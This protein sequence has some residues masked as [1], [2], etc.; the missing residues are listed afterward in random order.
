MIEIKTMEM[1]EKIGSEFAGQATYMEPSNGNQNCR[2]E[3]TLCVCNLTHEK[4]NHTDFLE[5]DVNADL[6]YYH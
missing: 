2:H 6:N 1:F 5:P 4:E 3:R